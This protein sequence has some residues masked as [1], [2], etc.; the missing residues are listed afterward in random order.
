[1]V[2]AKLHCFE[3]TAFICYTSFNNRE[4]IRLTVFMV[5]RDDLLHLRQLC[6]AEPLPRLMPPVDKD[7]LPDVGP[8]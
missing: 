8:P 3:G 2:D 7:T 6:H 1:M 5:P 4:Q